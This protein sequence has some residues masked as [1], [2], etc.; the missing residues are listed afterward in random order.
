MLLINKTAWEQLPEDLQKIVE[1]AA[2][3]LNNAIYIEFEAKNVEALARLVNK[4]H[5]K[6]SAFPPTVLAELKKLT[7]QVLEEKATQDAMFS[8]VYHSYQQFQAKNIQWYK[9][10]EHVYYHALDINP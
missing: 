8:K 1:I 6:L 3:S 7:T 10:T 9:I 4:Q 2:E 5:V